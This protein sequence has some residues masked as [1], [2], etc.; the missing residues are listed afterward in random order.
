M[1]FRKID[2]RCFTLNINPTVLTTAQEK[3]VRIITSKSGRSFPTF[4]KKKRLIQN[5]RL[6]EIALRPHLDHDT[7]MNDGDTAI[8]LEIVYMF[9]YTTSTPKWKREG[10]AFMT[11]R[12]DADN[13]SKSVVDCMTRIGFWA[14]DSMV[15]FKFIKFRFSVPRIDIKY[16]VWKQS[17]Q[18]ET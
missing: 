2:E 7:I 9:P 17:R 3:G 1:T 13:I 6:L 14:D 12:P 16:E 4:Y 10:L 18:T 8:L 5:E 15:N 11:Q